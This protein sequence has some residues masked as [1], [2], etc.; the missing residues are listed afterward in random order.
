MFTTRVHTLNLD[1]SIF[2]E[3]FISLEPSFL[4]YPWQ[5]ANKIGFALRDR[6]LWNLSPGII[7]FLMNLIPLKSCCILLQ[8]NRGPLF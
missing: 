3:D 2:S 8:V 4:H 1:N 6:R 5:V 7:A